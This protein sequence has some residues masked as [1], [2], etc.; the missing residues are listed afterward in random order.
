MYYS[1]DLFGFERKLNLVT[2]NASSKKFGKPLYIFTQ[3]LCHEQNVT[4][5]IF[6]WIEFLTGLNLVFFFQDWLPYQS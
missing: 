2:R 3:P 5:S 1:V 4:K 6:K